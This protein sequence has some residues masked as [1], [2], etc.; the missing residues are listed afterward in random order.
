MGPNAGQVS[1]AQQLLR[2]LIFARSLQEYCQVEHNATCKA[3]EQVAEKAVRELS[4]ANI[5]IKL[6]AG[7]RHGIRSAMRD[8]PHAI[9]DQAR[10]TRRHNGANKRR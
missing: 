5:H 10:H 9:A 8:C 4:T 7:R 3:V 6:H 1:N 2:K